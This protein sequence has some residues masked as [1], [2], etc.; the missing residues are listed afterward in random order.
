[1]KVNGRFPL[2]K[3]CIH[4]IA[5][6]R[7]SVGSSSGVELSRIERPDPD[8]D[9]DLDPDVDVDVDVRGVLAGAGEVPGLG[10]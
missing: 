1:M 6:W 10:L 8:V 2:I 7:F 9:V 5:S 4:L 3:S